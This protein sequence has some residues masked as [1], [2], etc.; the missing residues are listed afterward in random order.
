[1][2]K[3]TAQ[4]AARAVGV[5]VRTI[6]NWCDL[7]APKVA[8]CRT[9]GG[10]IRF[11]D[12]QLAALVE[13]HAVREVHPGAEARNPRFNAGLRVVTPITKARRRGGTAA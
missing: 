13:A 1:M 6:Q 9:P 12:E 2:A 5:H 10:R 4:D 7:D 8:H 11:T 3:H